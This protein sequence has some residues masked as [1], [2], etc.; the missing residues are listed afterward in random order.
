MEA[1][2]LTVHATQMARERGIQDEWIRL[3]LR[4]PCITKPDE[5]DEKLTCVF[6]RIPENGNRMLRLVIDS[7]QNPPRVITLFFDRKASREMP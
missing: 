4:D 7:A 2:L 1:F 5:R 3:V 6:R